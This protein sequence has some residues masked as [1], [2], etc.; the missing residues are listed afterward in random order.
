VN[1]AFTEP[2]IAN[3]ALAWLE[4]RYCALHGPDIAQ[5]EPPAERILK[6]AK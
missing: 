6:E 2:V 1:R 3:A 5:G 4:A